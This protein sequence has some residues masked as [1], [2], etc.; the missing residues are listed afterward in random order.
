[1]KDPR[2]DGFYALYLKQEQE[3]RA[4]WAEFPM[5]FDEEVASAEAEAHRRTVARLR[6]VPAFSAQQFKYQMDLAKYS[7]A[8]A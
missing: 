7:Q 6:P 4:D 1:M 8:V 3:R 5:P 2:Y